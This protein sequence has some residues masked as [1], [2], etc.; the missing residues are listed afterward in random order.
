MRLTRI[1]ANNYKG[2][3]ELELEIRP[4]NLI[5]GKNGSGKSTI[6]RL[7]PFIIESLTSKNEDLEFSPLG[8]NIG[9]KYTDLIHMGIE[10]K[11]LSLGAEFETRGGRTY[12]VLTDFAYFNEERTVAIQRFS[13]YVDGK[14]IFRIALE[15]FEEG[16]RIYEESGNR[17][18]VQFNCML[19]KVESISRL[20]ASDHFRQFVDKLAFFSDTTSYLGPFRKRARRVYPHTLTNYSTVGEDGRFAPFILYHD[21]RTRGTLGKKLK[22]WMST[23][24]D[25]KYVEPK[26][27]DLGFSVNIMNGYGE[28]N[29]VDDGVGFSQF[30]P[31]IVNNFLWRGRKSI[32]IVEQPEIHLHPGVSGSVIELYFS[33][34]QSDKIFLLETHSK[35]VVL[36]LRRKLVGKSEEFTNKFQVIYVKKENESCEV[37]YIYIDEKGGTNWW[38]EGI[39]EES[40]REVK[41]I[42]N[43]K[44]SLNAD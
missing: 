8:I 34:L 31:L 10:T 43:A 21:K 30:Y 4:F 6:T 27:G 18:D 11:S 14:L 2:F 36:R 3:K 5:I 15:K 38:P 9:D 40:Y 12:R 7:I 16:K 24:F 33:E 13:F 1:L 37:D 19:P 42:N 26:I 25:G 41:A 28:N 35:E 22:E 23:H 39:F 29:I 20:D 32:E 44:G 17:I